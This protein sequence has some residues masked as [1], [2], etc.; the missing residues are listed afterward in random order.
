MTPQYFSI[1]INTINPPDGCLVGNA[2]YP[3]F[4]LGSIC[5]IDF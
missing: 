3:E 2:E 1:T 5:N 4:S